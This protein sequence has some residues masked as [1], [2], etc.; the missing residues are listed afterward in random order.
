MNVLDYASA[1]Q[2]LLCCADAI[3]S[4]KPL[5]TEVDSKIGDGDHGIGMSIGMEKAKEV[6]WSMES[7]NNIYD[8]FRE[9]GKAMLM[10][11]GGASGVIF[12]TM[13]T[14]GAKQGLLAESMDT[15]TFAEMMWESLAAVKLRGKAQLGDKTMVDA[16]EPAVDAMRAYSGLDFEGML[17]AAVT[18][19]AAGVEKTKEI[20][21][22]FGRAKFLGERSVGYQDAGATSV[23]LL[24]QAMHRYLA[25]R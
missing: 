6:L 3:I 13:F 8:L 2:M 22:R 5:L 10:N 9:T 14:G 19:A 25:G 7:G 11:M 21:A 1:R 23:W 18:A 24:F 17:E 12:G 16:F 4:N 20:P 15:G